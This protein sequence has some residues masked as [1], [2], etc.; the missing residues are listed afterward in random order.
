MI[1]DS[2]NVTDDDRRYQEALFEFTQGTG[3]VFDRAYCEAQLPLVAPHHPKVLSESADGLLMGMYTESVYSV[4]LELEWSVFGNAMAFQGLFVDLKQSCFASK[5]AW[6]MF[7]SRR[8]K[9][10]VTICGRIDPLVI[11]QHVDEWR[12]QL[13]QTSLQRFQVVGL[14]AGQFNRGRLYAKL[15]PVPDNSRA[16]LRE[17]ADV[18][19]CAT[20]P[21]HLV[22]LFNLTDELSEFEAQELNRLIQKWWNVSYFTITPTHLTLSSTRDHLNLTVA[23]V[24]RWS[25]K[26]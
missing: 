11:Q 15:R 18:L 10:H 26:V 3:M 7:E 6:D 17:L 25:L 13:A 4:I 20:T 19:G 14:F 9:L 22:G 16:S 12:A 24:D 1:L 21:I 8:D 2:K 23:A 5:I